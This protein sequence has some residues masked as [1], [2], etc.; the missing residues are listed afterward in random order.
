MKKGISN[1][2]SII[3]GARKYLGRE[4]GSRTIEDSDFF[5]WKSKNVMLIVEAKVD[6]NAFVYDN[7]GNN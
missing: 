3:E 4:S 5:F 7:Y 1:F 6:E 2:E